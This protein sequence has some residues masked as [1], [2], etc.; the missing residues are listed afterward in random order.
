M[1]QINYNHLLDLF[2]MYL[3]FLMEIYLKGFKT[4]YSKLKFNLLKMLLSNSMTNQIH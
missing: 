3:E 4:L 2:L 1:L